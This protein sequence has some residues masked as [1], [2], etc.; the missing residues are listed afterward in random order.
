VRAPGTDRRFEFGRSFL[1]VILE[2]SAGTV[3]SGRRPREEPHER[4]I[5]AW[6]RNGQRRN[7]RAGSRLAA[8]LRR[9]PVYR[10]RVSPSR[11]RSATQYAG[12]SE[13]MH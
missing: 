3:W 1:S 9:Q 4:G 10:Q 13:P 2:W 6:G 12:S 8:I 5:L 11:S 7:A